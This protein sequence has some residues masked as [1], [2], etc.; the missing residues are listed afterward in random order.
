MCNLKIAELRVTAEELPGAGECRVGRY[1][2]E[3]ANFQCEIN[4]LWE[5]NVCVADYS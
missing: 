2:S 4:K 1:W 3:G 5:S